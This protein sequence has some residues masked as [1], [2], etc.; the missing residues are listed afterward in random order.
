MADMRRQIFHTCGTD[1]K[2]SVDYNIT[3]FNIIR[4][5]GRNVELPQLLTEVIQGFCN[6]CFP[7]DLFIGNL[8]SK[9]WLSQMGIPL[10]RE[11]DCCK[12]NHMDLVRV[13]I[14]L[15]RKSNRANW[16]YRLSIRGDR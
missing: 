4:E 1:V 5:Y 7:R 14:Q 11:T 6:F 13:S 8:L 9:S 3:S 10:S 2:G 12:S 15:E 16:Y